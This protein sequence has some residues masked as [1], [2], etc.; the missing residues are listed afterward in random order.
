MTLL[1]NPIVERETRIMTVQCGVETRAFVCK[2]PETLLNAIIMAPCVNYAHPRVDLHGLP[3]VQQMQSSSLY[4]KSGPVA[5]LR[6]LC[7]E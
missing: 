7:T 2:I 3:S 4:G 5:S 1:L 6:I